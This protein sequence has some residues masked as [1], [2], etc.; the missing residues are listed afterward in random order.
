MSSLFNIDRI[1]NDDLSRL[2]ADKGSQGNYLILLCAFAE[3]RHFEK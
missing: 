2:S 3:N 1:L